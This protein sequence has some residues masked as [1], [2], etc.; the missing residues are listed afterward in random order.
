MSSHTLTISDAYT[1]DSK[2]DVNGNDVTSPYTLQ[3]GDV[4]NVP[5]I[6]EGIVING[7]SYSTGYEGSLNIKSEDIAITRTGPERT[8][9]PDRPM[10]YITIHYTA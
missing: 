9:D 7:T 4:I 3:N 6:T 1:Y 10:T 8:I 5:T 2:I